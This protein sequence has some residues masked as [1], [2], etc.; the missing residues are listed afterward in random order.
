[1]LEFIIKLDTSL[2]LLLNGCHSSF[3]DEVMCKQKNGMDSIVS[4]YCRLARLQIPLEIFTDN[5]FSNNLGY[6][7]RSAGSQAV[8]RDLGPGVHRGGGLLPASDWAV[9]VVGRGPGG[10]P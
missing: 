4:G 7:E 6:S 3:W 10:E 9:S 8:Q 2:F 1:M 5:Y